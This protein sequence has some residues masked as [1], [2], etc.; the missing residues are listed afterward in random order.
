MELVLVYGEK[1]AQFLF[2]AFKRV[3][4]CSSAC[5]LSEGTRQECA[6]TD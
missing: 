1:L 2:M 3:P 6:P 4:A 5:L